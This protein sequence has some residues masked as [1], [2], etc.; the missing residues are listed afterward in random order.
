[1]PHRLFELSKEVEFWAHRNMAYRGASHDEAESVD[2]IARVWDKDDVAG[3]GNRLREIGEPLFR[4]ERD[5]NLALGVELDPEAARVIAG[6]GAAQPRNAT[7]YGISVRPR[8]LHRFDEFGDDMGRGRS[9]GITHTEIDDVASRG[10]RRRLQRIDLA[11]DIGGEA[12][13]AIELFGHGSRP[14]VSGLFK[15]ASQFWRVLYRSATIWGD[16]RRHFSGCT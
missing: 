1:M 7:R 9:V 2:R 5:D 3:C 4:S 13:D 8:I 11:E 12:L 14:Q 15:P 10:A 6:A 16:G